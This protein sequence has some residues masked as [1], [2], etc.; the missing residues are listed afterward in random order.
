MSFQ[1]R[2]CGF[3]LNL[4]L[5]ILEEKNVKKFQRHK[6]IAMLTMPGIFFFYISHLMLRNSVLRIKGD[7]MKLKFSNNKK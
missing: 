1:K 4:L 6:V 5:N 7:V 2:I 3:N